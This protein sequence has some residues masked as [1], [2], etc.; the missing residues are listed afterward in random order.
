MASNYALTSQGRVFINTS[1]VGCGNPYNFYS[2][3]K[4]DS[5]DKSFGDITSIY[6]PSETSYDEF[7]EVAS[8]KGADSRWTSTLT[9]VLFIDEQT[10]LEYLANQG[11]AFNMQVHYGVCTRPDDFINFDSALIFEDVRLTSYGLST[12]TARTP[13]ERAV[14]EESAAISIGNVYRVFNM[15]VNNLATNLVGNSV[16]PFGVGNIDSKSCGGACTTLS[17][18]C[19]RWAVG[20]F[21]NAD[22]IR[23]LYTDN[24]GITWNIRDTGIAELHDS[25]ENTA[26]FHS[27]TSYSYITVR[28]GSLAYYY[29]VSNASIIDDTVSAELIAGPISNQYVY[30]IGESDNYIWFVGQTGTTG[31]IANVHKSSNE[32]TIIAATGTNYPVSVNAISDNTVIVGARNGVVYFSNTYGVFNTAAS[33]PTAN[34]IFGVHAF[35]TTSWLVSNFDGLFCTSDSGATWTQLLSTSGRG[36]LSFY[37][38][39][40]GYYVADNAVYRTFDGG[41]TWKKISSPTITATAKVIACPSDPNLFMAVGGTAT[42]NQFIIKGSN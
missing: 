40:V 15:T 34:T 27:S 30:D 16:V 35:S 8:I 4:V 13:D 38:D 33:V 39:I 42:A 32:F 29:R 2:C 7:V 36:R 6:C 19:S 18:G 20:Y 9:G 10:A 21:T 37:D 41:N 1:G 22:V 28:D 23:I 11:C 17:D 25:T 24:G 3:M 26:N 14:I 12:L 5:V 31:F